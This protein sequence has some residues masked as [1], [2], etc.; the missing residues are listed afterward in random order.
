MLRKLTVEEWK[1]YGDEYQC[2]LTSSTVAEEADKFMYSGYYHG[3][4]ADTMPKAL[5]NAREL[6]SER[7]QS[8][9]MSIEI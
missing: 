7:A 3:E 2:L 6:I 4:L 9:F 1:S 8:L 5:S